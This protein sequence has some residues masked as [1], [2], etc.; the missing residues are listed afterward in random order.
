MPPMSE[1][2]RGLMAQEYKASHMK[3]GL[4]AAEKIARRAEPSARAQ[5]CLLQLVLPDLV[6]AIER[7]IIESSDQPRVRSIAGGLLTYVYNPLDLIGDDTP[8]GRLDDVIICALGLQRLRELEKLELEP[9]VAAVCELAVR[10]LSLLDE[11]LKN[12]IEWFIRDLESST[13]P[14]PAARAQL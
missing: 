5:L 12:S 7:A 4:A 6:S 8:L 14:A 10:S 3:E 2:L 1:M 11:E 9:H 13:E